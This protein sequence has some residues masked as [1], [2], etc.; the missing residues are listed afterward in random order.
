MN[1][2]KLLKVNK[3]V[4]LARGGSGNSGQVKTLFE[5]N[6]H[7]NPYEDYE[8]LVIWQMTEP[9]RLSYYFNN[10]LHD[11]MTDDY[12]SYKG[13]IK[14][15]T[16]LETDSNMWKGHNLPLSDATLESVFYY[17]I[18]EFVCEQNNWKLLTFAPELIHGDIWQGQAFE[19]F[20][21]SDNYHR[22]NIFGRD[23]D[24]CDESKPYLLSAICGHHN[25]EGYKLIAQ[26]IF[27]FIESYLDD[28]NVSL[29]LVGMPVDLRGAPTDSTAM[30]KKF[31]AKLAVQFSSI[32]IETYDERYTS[33]I[34]KDSL[35][36]LGKNKKYRRKKS[37]I[38]KVSASL[39]LQSYL[40]RNS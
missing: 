38:D 21:K 35:I 24:Y 23:Y 13:Y 30:T 32:K 31:I 12:E 15:M 14:D 40:I 20:L 37:N 5:K 2:A 7:K 8:V 9:H 25:E 34:A 27:D 4:N 33:K 19:H 6:L 36:F 17:K 18:L 22:Y 16:R 3:L 10:E 28:N 1:L 11:V 29:F 39:I 26:K